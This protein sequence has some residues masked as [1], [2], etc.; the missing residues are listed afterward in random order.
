LKS[1]LIYQYRVARIFL[2]LKG[3]GAAMNENEDQD[4]IAAREWYDRKSA[5]MVEIL[6]EEHNMV[7]HAIIPYAIGGGLDLYYFPNGIEGT[8]VATKELS[9][10]PGEGSSNDVFDCYEL[11]DVHT[12]ADFARRCTRRVDTFWQCSQINECDSE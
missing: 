6:G 10:I 12:P 8:G 5:L 1:V 2:N 7:M 4:E 9:E 11:V 3:E